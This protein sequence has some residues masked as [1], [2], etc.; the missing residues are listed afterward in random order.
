MP[1]A[2]CIPASN[3]QHTKDHACTLSGL[4]TFQDTSSALCTLLPLAQLL[5]LAEHLCMY[6][7]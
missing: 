7:N 2:G 4:G 6:A 1:A 3:Q 5:S